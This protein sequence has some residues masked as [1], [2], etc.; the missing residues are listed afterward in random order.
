MREMLC[1]ERNSP[2]NKQ[3]ISDAETHIGMRFAKDYREFLLKYNG[4]LFEEGIFDIPA[5]GKSSV[6]FFGIGTNEEHSDL[7]HNF[8]AYKS[9]LPNN[10][11]PIGFDP[12]G[13]LVCMAF[14]EGRWDV[15]FWDHEEENNPPKLENMVLLKCSF[16]SFIEALE[17]EEGE[18]W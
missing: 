13:N 18:V 14:D 9:R 7:V 15:F 4:G 8:E 17:K 10:T 16:T 11:V 1:I 12:G 6:I 2:S 3:A 5:R